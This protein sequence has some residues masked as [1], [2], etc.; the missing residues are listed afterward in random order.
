MK[1]TAENEIE[2]ILS[3]QEKLPYLKVVDFFEKCQHLLLLIPDT[4]LNC[5]LNFNGNI[6]IDLYH[7]EEF[8]KKSLDRQVIMNPIKASSLINLYLAK[9]DISAVDTKTVTQSIPL[10]KIHI[11]QDMDLYH[12]LNSYLDQKYKSYYLK[13]YISDS[14]PEKITEQTKII[15]I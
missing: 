4:I 13:N 12:F 8:Y 7:K 11:S 2:Y 5:D 9:F 10:S 15:K 6:W 1:T 14:I 3:L